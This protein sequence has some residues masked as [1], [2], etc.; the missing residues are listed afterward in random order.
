MDSQLPWMLS[1]LYEELADA[2]FYTGKNH[3][4]EAFDT[5]D[6][7]RHNLDWFEVEMID[8]FR[9]QHGYTW[10]SLAAA[11]G[12]TRQALRARYTRRQRPEH[13]NSA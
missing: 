6:L 8:T 12:T 2:A 1:K 4:S 7:V 5:L 13:P 11:T 3:P 10:H 9:H